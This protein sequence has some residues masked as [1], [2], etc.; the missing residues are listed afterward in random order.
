MEIGRR[1]VKFGL[2]LRGLTDGAMTFAPVAVLGGF[3]LLGAF[4]F[5]LIGYRA[6]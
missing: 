3:G 5:L 4:V 6:E 1:N 2:I